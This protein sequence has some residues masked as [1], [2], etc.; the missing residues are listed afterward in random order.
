VTRTLDEVEL[1]RD[2]EDSCIAVIGAAERLSALTGPSL[3]GDPKGSKI[4]VRLDFGDSKRPYC[5][6]GGRSGVDLPLLGSG[7]DA[8]RALVFGVI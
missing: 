6:R 3:K 8:E 2:S 1:S 4:A 5:G 7:T